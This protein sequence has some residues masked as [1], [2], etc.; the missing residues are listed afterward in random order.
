[1]AEIIS[2]IEDSNAQ[3]RSFGFTLIA[4][5]F[6]WILQDFIRHGHAIDDF[7]TDPEFIF[8]NIGGLDCAL[9]FAFSRIL[10]RYVLLRVPSCHR[11]Y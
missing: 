5:N 10:P 6:I 1:M 9:G 3:Q 2:D 8:S 7:V 11:E 4:A